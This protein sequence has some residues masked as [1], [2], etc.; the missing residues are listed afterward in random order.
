M[1]DQAKALQDKCLI[2]QGAPQEAEIC[3][4]EED[5]E[6]WREPYTDYLT[7]GTLPSDKKAALR[8]VKKSGRYFVLDR[9]L[10]RKSFSQQTLTFL[11]KAE[12]LKVMD[13][14]HD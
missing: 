12:A 10:F 8:L 13:L 14:T 4:A 6:D 11:D 7:N 3:I 5:S 1:V 9:K 2:C